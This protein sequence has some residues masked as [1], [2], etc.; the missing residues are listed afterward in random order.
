VELVPIFGITGNSKASIYAVDGCRD[1]IFI[2]S[3]DSD[4]YMKVLDGIPI[5]NESVNRNMCCV[6]SS[7][8]HSMVLNSREECGTND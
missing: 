5:P 7:K 1:S 3:L 2:W 8:D 6:K 4:I